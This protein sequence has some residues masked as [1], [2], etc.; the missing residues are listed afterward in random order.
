MIHPC[1]PRR[2]LRG[3][4]EWKNAQWL[5]IKI[6]WVSRRRVFCE[7]KARDENDSVRK[8]MLFKQQFNILLKRKWYYVIKGSRRFM[9]R[10][11]WFCITCI[12]LLC[13]FCSLYLH[14]R[15]NMRFFLFFFPKY[16]SK[17]MGPPVAERSKARVY[18]RSL[19]GIASSNPAGGMDVCLF[20]VL[21]VVR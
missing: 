18:G 21:R 6:D 20:R 4:W 14:V 7:R 9:P 3:R 1:H 15:E 11:E 2:A 13:S 17:F 16:L 8:S 10:V 12:I 19:A 5:Q